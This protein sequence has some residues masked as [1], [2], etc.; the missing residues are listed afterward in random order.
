M[1]STRRRVLQG[2]GLALGGIFAGPGCAQRVSSDPASAGPAVDPMGFAD[3][4]N[5]WWDIDVIGDPIKDNQLLWYLSQVGQGQADVGEC[6]DTA[7]RIS[8]QEDDTWL[9]EWMK[10]ARRVQAVAEESLAGGH[11]ISAGET[12]LRAANYYRAAVIHHVGAGEIVLEAC[13]A[14]VHCYEQAIALLK[15]PGQAVE[16]P[17]EGTTLP[18]W[19]FRSPVAGGKAPT[20]VLHQGMHAWPE[21]TK[22]VLDGGLKRGYHVLF[23]H[24]PGQ[25][26]PLRR[27]GLPFRPDWEKVVT[28]AVDFAL[29]LPGVDPDRLIL[30]GLS[31]GGALSPR[32][33]A[34]EKRIQICV[35]NPGVLNWSEAFFGNFLRY[36]PDLGD[37]LDADPEQFDQA[38]WGMAAQSPMLDWGIRDTMW[39]YGGDT[40]AQAIRGIRAYNNEEVVD[41]IT[42]EMLVMDRT[43]ETFSAGQAEK[44]M[45]ALSSPKQYLLFTAED[46]GLVHCQT[47]A[48]SVATQRMYD[49]L[50]K[51]V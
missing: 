51:M 28:P 34:F 49:A 6:L 30:N 47:G 45:N 19:F 40:P 14:S 48:L 16:I 32:A 41:Q 42:C 26:L 36:I 21:E 43:A 7:S 27:Q 18:G 31:F 15:M 1:D 37:M 8:A 35:P 38:V 44:L 3:Q 33:A 12:F 39:K 20:I 22:W 2:M 10:T 46:T 9:H 5:P 23:F 25:G 29:T 11:E 13:S 17:Y 24:G 4:E 50:D